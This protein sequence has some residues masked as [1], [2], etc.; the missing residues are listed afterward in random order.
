MARSGLGR[1]AA[2][3][4]PTRNST[5]APRSKRSVLS[6]NQKMRDALAKTAK[7]W[8]QGRRNFFP[9]TLNTLHYECG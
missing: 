1:F 3:G 6:V 7:R 9:M 2:C 5:V 8:R 4:P